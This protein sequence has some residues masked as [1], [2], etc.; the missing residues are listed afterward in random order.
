MDN[1]LW[2]FSSF[3]NEDLCVLIFHRNN[4]SHF[5]MDS[6]LKC[7]PAHEWH[8]FGWVICFLFFFFNRL[9]FNTMCM[10]VC[11]VGFGSSIECT[12]ISKQK[13]FDDISLHLFLRLKT[14]PSV[15]Y[16]IYIPISEPLNASNS[17]A[18]NMMLNPI[19]DRLHSFLHRLAP[20]HACCHETV[21]KWWW[22]FLGSHIL[23]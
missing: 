12:V 20:L 2:N 5:Q 7:S 23:Q 4:K 9:C 21:L 18:E 16:Q 10:F 6:L 1:Q 17:I 15:Q 3:Y 14:E 19:C 13:L 8:G 22:I 11:F